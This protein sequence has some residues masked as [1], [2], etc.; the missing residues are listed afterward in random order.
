MFRFHYK[1]FFI[2]VLIFLIELSI[3]LFN[4]NNFIR[5]YLG[6]IL[7]VI[8]IYTSSRTILNSDIK[9]TAFAILIFSFT[10]EIFQY[11]GGVTLLGLKNNT[12]ARIIIGTTFSWIDLLAYSIGFGIII[13]LEKIN[14]SHQHTLAN[15]KT[16]R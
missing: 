4:F 10:T 15:M 14:L 3:A 1:Y 13:I 9:I 11:F 5:Y 8:L 2:S 12:I 16:V 7:V 6:D